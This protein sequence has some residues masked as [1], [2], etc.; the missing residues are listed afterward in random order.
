MSTNTFLAVFVGSKTSPQMLTWSSLFTSE[1]RAR[2]QK[3]IA[4]WRSKH[5]VLETQRLERSR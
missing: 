5:Q 4:A 3:A 2:E 1:R